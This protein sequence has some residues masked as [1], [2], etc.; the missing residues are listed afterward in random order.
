MGDFNIACGISHMS[1]GSGDTCVLIPLTKT[2]HSDDTFDGAYYVS[3]DGPIGRFYPLTLPIFGEYNSY[4]CLENI[5]ENVNTKAIEKYYG[6]SIDDFAQHMCSSHHSP[7]TANPQAP[8]E[9]YGMFV[10]R[11]VYDLLS[12]NPIGEWGK[13]ETAAN[14]CDMS[15]FVLRYLG[16]VEDKTIKAGEQERYNRAFKHEKIP[17]LI[18]W[19]DGRWIELQVDDK[20]K[21]NLGIYHPEQFFKFLKKAGLFVP[22]QY[23]SLTKMRPGEIHYDM[24]CERILRF[25]EMEKNAKKLEEGS[26]TNDENIQ[27]IRALYQMSRNFDT[28]R[29]IKFGNWSDNG[30][31][32]RE[33][34]GDLFTDSTFR[35]AMI[36]WKTFQHQLWMTNTP[37]MPSWSGIQYGCHYATA[38]LA[39]LTER[40]CNKEI[41][42][43]R[44]L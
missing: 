5:E 20:K 17:N 21:S 3:N 19:S 26:S 25:V 35:T 38:R 39:K 11:E 15:E 40:L 2:K 24:D 32:L 44:N 4:G 36:D 31:L 22:P 43:E 13:K 9:S 6:C 10:K 16:F 41:K 7:I 23:K 42:E 27:L 29:Y 28:C 8:K 14:D 18:V 12:K 34:Y 1:I 30:Q 33:I 37:I